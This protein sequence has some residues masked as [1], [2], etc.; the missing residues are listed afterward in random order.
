M[1][2]TRGSK[3]EQKPRFSF[4][5][6]GKREREMCEMK[7]ENERRSLTSMASL[8][9]WEERVETRRAA[10]SERRGAMTLGGD[11]SFEVS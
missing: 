9:W 11:L 4:G 8:K 2:G 7:Q 5:G 1:R 3:S 10:G 6:K